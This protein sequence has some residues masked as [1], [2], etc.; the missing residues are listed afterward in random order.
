MALHLERAPSTLRGNGNDHWSSAVFPFHVHCFRKFAN[1]L[2]AAA[3]NIS[4]L[5][6]SFA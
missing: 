4:I 6:R 3:R 2:R 1:I 5:D